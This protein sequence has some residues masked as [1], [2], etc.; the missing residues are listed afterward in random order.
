M[1]E[2]ILLLIK[3]VV[4]KRNFDLTLVVGGVL[5]GLFLKLNIV[6]IAILVT[7]IWFILNPISAKYFTLISGVLFFVTPFLFVMGRKGQAEEF[8]IYT[9]Y[10]L[11]LSVIMAVQEHRAIDKAIK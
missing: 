11:I 6:D 9:Y 2:K 8:A 10:F 1:K 3:K 4:T 5:L 7:F